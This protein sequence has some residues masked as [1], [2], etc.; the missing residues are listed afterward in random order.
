MLLPPWTSCC[1]DFFG[2]YQVRSMVNSRAKMKTW[3]VVFVCMTTGS[4]HVELAQGYDVKSFLT[5]FSNFVSIRGSPS[6]MYSDQGS[7]LRRASEDLGECDWE[8][9]AQELDRM[10]EW[11]FAPSHTPWRNGVAEAAVKAMKASLDVV[12]AA[13]A[14]NLTFA[15]FQ[16]VLKRA[17]NAVNDRPLGVKKATVGEEEVLVPVTCN[18]LLLGRAS[19]QQHG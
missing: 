1:V 3:P 17:A 9:A 5:T 19:T 15:E 12:M 13:G 18:S 10:V 16:A 7:Q 11:K 8:S 4:V 6:T 2:P 14:H